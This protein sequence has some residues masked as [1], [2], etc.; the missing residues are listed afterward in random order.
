MGPLGSKV[1]P[2]RGIWK[3]G[4]FWEVLRVR[5]SKLIFLGLWGVPPRLKERSLVGP[6]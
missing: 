3:W 1:S 5:P 2:Y 6:I 4:F